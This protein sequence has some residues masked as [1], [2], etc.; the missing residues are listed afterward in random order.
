MATKKTMPKGMKKME[1]TTSKKMDK[2]PMMG[3]KKK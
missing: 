3:Y 2:K 1:K